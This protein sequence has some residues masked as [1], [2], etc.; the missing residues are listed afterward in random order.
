ML[1]KILAVDDTPENL[2][3]IAGVL[4]QA[5]YD[6]RPVTSGQEALQIASVDPPDLVLLDIRMPEMDGFAVC[7]HLKANPL[8]AGIPIVFLSASG[9]LADKL[10]AFEAGG[11]DYI[12]KPF[13]EREV[14][15]RVDLQLR[16]RRSQR[17]LAA[18]R[19]LLEAKVVERTRELVQLAYFDPLTGLPNRKKFSE[20]ME[21]MLAA[22]DIREFALL[23]LDLDRFK[24]VNDALGHG[25]GDELLKQLAERLRTVVADHHG[26]VARLGGDEFV[27]CLDG[28]DVHAAEH[29]AE[30]ILAAIEA[31]FS[32]DGLSIEMGCSIGIAIYPR[33][34]DRYGELLRCA[35]VAMY[36]AKQTLARYSSYAPQQDNNSTGRL[37]LLS[38]FLDA[39]KA[40]HL[41]LHYQPKIEIA[42][43]KASGVEALVRWQHEQ[44]GLLPPSEFLPQIELTDMIRRLTHWVIDNAAAQVA[45]WLEQGLPVPVA[46]NL[47]ARNL[48]EEDLPDWIAHVL[49]ARAIPPQLLEVEITET[50][51]MVAPDRS[52]AV[53][54]RIAALGVRVAV[55]DFGTGY[56]SFALL[57]RLPPG[58]SLKI[59]R[60]FVERIADAPAD[61]AIVA[62]MIHLGRG[63]SANVIAEGVESTAV[64]HRLSSLGCQQAQGYLIA[65]PMTE[66]AVRHW[67]GENRNTDTTP[68]VCA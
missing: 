28:S 65:R 2:R 42:S 17:D 39:L 52:L 55:D 45:H 66:P 35:D 53:L 31:P 40:D 21:R 37:T 10:Q 24:S 14:L 68:G 48:V 34:G 61:E 51:M 44:H 60:S 50:A 9:D 43:G 22:P 26:F 30:V 8:T 13:H 59:D 6:V 62:S 25:V 38:Q 23:L 15:A 4:L 57:R 7:A 27:V 41:V 20:E 47:S 32:L 19:D 56:S 49:R 58:I 12:E 3:V 33:N 11:A 67:L 29:L 64:L 36:V 46:V 1:G 16:L 18:A 54:G 63:L 5:G